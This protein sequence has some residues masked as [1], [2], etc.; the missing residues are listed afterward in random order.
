M[1]ESNKA[2]LRNLFRTRRHNLTRDKRSDASARIRARLL[3]LPETRLA[4]SVLLYV[5]TK[6]E[7]DTWPLLEHFWTVGVQV[8]LP[9]CRDN[10]PGFMDIHAVNSAAELGPGQFGLTEPIL[11]L[12]PLV[13]EP[14]PDLILVPA[15]AFDRRG[16]RL[17]FGGGYYDR[18]LT[19]LT[20]PHL[21]V[22]LAYD[23]QIAERLPAEPWDMPVQCIITQD[24]II[25]TENQ[26]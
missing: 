7:V 19:C 1:Q 23:F 12:A 14:E 22:G 4:G 13:T 5:P 8:L 16:F 20:H 11:G 26:S 25:F 2:E 17:G 24:T 18:F 9:R 3:D 6:N 10:Q 15:L 21:R